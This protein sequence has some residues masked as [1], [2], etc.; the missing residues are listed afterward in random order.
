MVKPGGW[1][2]GIVTRLTDELSEQARQAGVKVAWVWVVPSQ[3]QLNEISALISADHLKPH[4]S[5]AFAL[6][7]VADAHHAQET[8]RTVGKIVLTVT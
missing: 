1:V 7:Q 2:V 8:G 4:V 3:A 6:E 5:Q